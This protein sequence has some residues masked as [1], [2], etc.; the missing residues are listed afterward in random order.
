ME[1]EGS[2]V[3]VNGLSPFGRTRMGL[4]G[5]DEEDPEIL[6]MSEALPPPEQNSPVAE[7]LLS[8]LSAGVNGQL[9]RIDR[10][11]LQLYTH[12][13]LLLPAV[14]HPE[15]TAEAV[16]EAFA[17]ELKDRPGRLRSPGH[18]G[19][20]RFA[21]ERLLEAHREVLAR[22]APTHVSAGASSSCQSRLSVKD[23]SRVIPRWS[24]KTKVTASQSM[25]VTVPGRH[26]LPI[27]S[28]ITALVRST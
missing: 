13:A 3:R 1:L 4:T 24:V 19:A 18:D 28:S 21:P 5:G 10:G 17:G 6:R 14:V 12:P 8:D 15:W 23:G 25:G 26:S 2:G 27:R 11:E 16:A 7:Y 20:A 9:I 22:G